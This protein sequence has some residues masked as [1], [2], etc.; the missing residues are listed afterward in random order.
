FSAL[1]Q[2]ALFITSAISQQKFTPADSPRREYSLDLN[3]KFF[4]E[5]KAKA[6]DAAAAAFDDS[7]W[8]TVSTPHTYN[9]VDSFRT[10]ASHSGG[11][12]GTWKGTVW[13][14]KHF[15]LPPETNGKR[16]L[17]EFEGMRQAGE[18]FLN[19]TAVGL[20]E[21]GVTAYGVD[22]TDAVKFGEENILAVHVD[23]RLDYAER[24]T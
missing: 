1:A 24:A 18:I 20:S 4:K 2:C 6:S 19:G 16:V 17:L 3:W 13:Y 8:E 12:R 14:R 22:I 5:D 23:N 21:N 15:K 10:W 7:A 11:D 9:D